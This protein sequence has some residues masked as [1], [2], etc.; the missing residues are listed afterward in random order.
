MKTRS[1]T[2]WKIFGVAAVIGLVIALQQ[3]DQYY[4]SKVG[5]TDDHVEHVEFLN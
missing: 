5:A 1:I 3:L 4:A 2:L